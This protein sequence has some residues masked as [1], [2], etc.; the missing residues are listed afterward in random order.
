[1]RRALAVLGVLGLVIVAGCTGGVVTEEALSAQETYEWNTKAT[2]TVDVAGG[3]YE[4][5]YHLRNRSTIE[6][7]RP[8]RLGGTQPVPIRAVKFRYPDGRI[9]NASA[10]EV[11]E[12]GSK[13]VVNLPQ[14]N[15]SFA[16][17]VETNPGRLFVPVV[18]N[19]SYEVILPPGARVGFP[20]LGSV[21]P[22]GYE[23][24]F[25]SDRVHLRWNTIDAADI[26]ISYYLQRDLYLFGGLL[27]LLSLIAGGG[28]LY[29]RFQIK[30]LEQAREAVGLDLE[31]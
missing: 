21:D 16:Y 17:S 1:M 11:T 31:E 29:F 19:G 13:T 4:A 14:E 10:I 24:D 26:A 15:G 12:E 25:V 6:L 3:S 28:V 7:Y 18:V 30:N 20:I 8:G 5:V 23:K 22:G 2:V 9:V 27:A